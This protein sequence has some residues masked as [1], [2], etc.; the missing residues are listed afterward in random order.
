MSVEAELILAASGL[1]KQPT[2][3][4]VRAA[5]A[6]RVELVKW[7]EGLVAQTK[8]A[9]MLMPKT[10]ATYFDRLVKYVPQEE[11]Y[12]AVMG[13]ELA[14]EFQMLLQHATQSVL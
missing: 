7:A 10:R 6:L 12:A 14:V 9:K 11:D 13:P 1:L 8:P 5:K 2:R 3:E 4:H